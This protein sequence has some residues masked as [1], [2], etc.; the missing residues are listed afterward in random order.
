V[1]AG[2]KAHTA[3]IDTVHKPSLSNA[4]ALGQARLR[5]AKPQSRGHFTPR[6]HGLRAARPTTVA[7]SRLHDAVH[8]R[9]DACELQSSACQTDTTGHGTVTCRG[10]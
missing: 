5:M 1:H 7:L 3:Q 2:T 10:P 9:A 8:R 4:L 6:T